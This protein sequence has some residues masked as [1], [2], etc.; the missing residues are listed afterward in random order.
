MYVLIFAGRTYLPVGCLRCLR[1][2]RVR[3]A[4]FSILYSAVLAVERL[5]WH[6]HFLLVDGFALVILGF[7]HGLFFHV[8]LVLS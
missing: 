8:S 1:H 3:F 4:C 6:W 2:S 5:I 7:C